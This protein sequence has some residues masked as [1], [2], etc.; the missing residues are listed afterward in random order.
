M[1][2][3]R[4]QNRR[5]KISHAFVPL[6]WLRHFILSPNRIWHKNGIMKKRSGSETCSCGTEP[7][8]RNSVFSAKYRLKIKLKKK[9]LNKF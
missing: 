5:P 8:I 7:G 3:L 4:I 1:K 6:N 9:Y 2:L